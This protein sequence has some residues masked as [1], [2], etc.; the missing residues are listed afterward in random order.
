MDVLTHI[1]HTSEKYILS[2]YSPVRAIHHFWHINAST[3]FLISVNFLEFEKICFLSTDY[4]DYFTDYADAFKIKIEFVFPFL[5][6][7][8]N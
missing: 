2:L 3:C 7:F 8:W 1:F 4:L 6:N 5:Y